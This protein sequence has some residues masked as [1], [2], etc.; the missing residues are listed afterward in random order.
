MKQQNDSNFDDVGVDLK[1]LASIYTS[2]VGYG[3][4]AAEAADLVSSKAIHMAVMEEAQPIN[5]MAL[6]S[7]MPVLMDAVLKKGG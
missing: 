2:L 3:M 4:P 5:L 7:S 1:E 6:E